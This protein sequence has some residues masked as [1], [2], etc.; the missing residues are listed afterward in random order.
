MSRRLFSILVGLFLLAW[1]LSMLGVPGFAEAGTFIAWL[2]R[3]W[4]LLLVVWGAHLT[5]RGL[6]RQGAARGQG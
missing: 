2:F 3:L 4:P 1:G 5:Y 6:T